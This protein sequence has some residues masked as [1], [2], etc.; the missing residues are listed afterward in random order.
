MRKVGTITEDEKKELIKLYERKI[1]MEELKETF[2]N[3]DL[4]E[5]SFIKLKELYA[6]R[7]VEIV[8]EFDSW[9]ST[10]GEKYKWESQE[11]LSWQVDF[12][13]KEIFLV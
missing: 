4:E 12:K 13:T 6:K 11:G 10:M 2:N 9:W 7:K 1:A 8:D 3:S 5:E